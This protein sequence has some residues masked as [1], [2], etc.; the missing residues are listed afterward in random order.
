[1]HIITQNSKMLVM[2]I[3]TIKGDVADVWNTL[4]ESAEQLADFPMATVFEAQLNLWEAKEIGFECANIRIH[5]KRGIFEI[6][7]SSRNR[8]A[9]S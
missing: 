6:T 5:K 3:D 8:T 4:K 9:L 2:I 7:P 1:M